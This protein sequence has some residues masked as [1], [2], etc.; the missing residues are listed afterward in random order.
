MSKNRDTLFIEYGLGGAVVGVHM[1]RMPGVYDDGFRKQARAFSI[2]HDHEVERVAED[3][4]SGANVI[5]HW[6]S[7]T[8]QEQWDETLRIY[9]KYMREIP[10]TVEHSSIFDFFRAIGFDYSARKFAA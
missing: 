4:L 3:H 1:V 5:D 8:R 7:D 2:F 9:G 6:F 10:E